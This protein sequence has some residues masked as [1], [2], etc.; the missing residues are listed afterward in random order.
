MILSATSSDRLASMVNENYVTAKRV[1]YRGFC[2]HCHNSNSGFNDGSPGATPSATMQS[3]NTHATRYTLPITKFVGQMNGENV[4]SW[5][6]SLSTYFCT[7]PEMTED[8][9]LQIIGLQ[10]EGIADMVGHSAG[11]FFL[12]HGH[13]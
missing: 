7:C 5:L 3:S 2:I 13:R 1:I 8:M 12:G 6:H 9:K 11:E 10:L 4:D